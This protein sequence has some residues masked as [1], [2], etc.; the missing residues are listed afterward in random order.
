[1]ERQFQEKR[2][3][4]SIWMPLLLAIFLVG[5]M[6]IGLKLQK[7]KSIT[8]IE[9]ND[10]IN[11]KGHG[12]V[13]ELLRYIEA[14]YVDD[15][16]REQ[17]IDDAIARILEN[18]DP[19]SVYIPSKH[20]NRFD[21]PLNGD[22][23]GIGV[24]FLVIEDT[25]MVVAP[26]AGGPAD[27][28]GILAGDKIVSVSDSILAGNPLKMDKIMGMLRG[29]KGTPIE[30]GVLRGNEQE[31][32]HF[33]VIRGEI[34]INS[35]DVAYKIDPST[36]YVKISRFSLKTY[37]EFR[38]SLEKLAPEGADLNLIIDL[39]DNNGGYLQQ[40]TNILNQIINERDKLLVYTQGR[41]VKRTDYETTG[42]VY[43]DFK[44]VCVLI[45]ENSASASEILA[46]VVQ[47]Y[48]RGTIIGR[49]SFGKGLVQ[50]QYG[51]SDGSAL[52]L[53]VAR[54][55]TPSGRSIQRP[56]DDL[57]AYED[58]AANRYET[59]ELYSQNNITNKNQD[60]TTFFTENGRKVFGGGGIT[61]DIFVPLDS[62]RI[63]EDYLHL[64]AL[65]PEF[66]FRHME[67]YQS[68]YDM[69]F[70]R[71]SNDFQISATFFNTFLDFAKQR[72]FEE[73]SP[74]SKV[75]ERLKLKLK[76]RIAKHLY[77]DEG[78]FKIMNEEDQMVNKAMEVIQEE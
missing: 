33:E 47:D 56:Y 53:T 35:V 52:R 31:L 13:E 51:L 24:E 37:K 54:Y 67:Q 66:I 48:D 23:D 61:P 7:T 11:A 8:I 12:K 28:A 9:A 34:P 6:L 74:N 50:E 68:T 29:K 18:L 65:I 26:L 41:T 75:R 21:D 57:M 16:D 55:Y 63:S 10:A 62:F 17:L 3:F 20:L 15:V 27:N 25:L 19:H 44:K 77:D 32:R 59:G 78:F 36:V 60:S 40:A 69:E 58:D 46:G 64:N 42:P 76:S 43:Y 70:D 73:P 5:G 39:R 49:R 38:A 2:P 22:F 45:N 71:F 30:V 72:G 4:L 14:R 1:M